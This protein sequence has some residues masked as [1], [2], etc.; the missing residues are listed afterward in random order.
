MALQIDPQLIGN[1]SNFGRQ[2]AQQLRQ[3]LLTPVQM[4]PQDLLA[5]NIVSLF[6]GDP[7][8]AA[9][10]EAAKVK[11]QRTQATQIANEQAGLLGEAGAE[12]LRQRDA[13]LLSNADVINSVAT[14]QKQQAA[15]QAK[16]IKQ[17]GLAN[18]RDAVANSASPS[19]IA[20]I[21]RQLL[22]VGAT[23]A[24]LESARDSGRQ[25]KT[26]SANAI[27]VDLR[28]RMLVAVQSGDKEELARIAAEAREALPTFNFSSEYNNALKLNNE[29]MSAVTE[30]NNTTFNADLY[31]NLKEQLGAP[32]AEAYK[33]KPDNEEYFNKLQKGVTEAA[34][35]KA[36]AAELPLIKDRTTFNDAVGGE[37]QNV[38]AESDLSSKEQKKVEEAVFDAVSGLYSQAKDKATVDQVKTLVREALNDPVILEAMRS[39]DVT[40]S[41][42]GWFTGDDTLTGLIRNRLGVPTQSTTTDAVS[43]AQ[44]KLDELRKQQTTAN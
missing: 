5:R 22:S 4:A 15:A 35:A 29:M 36:E 42:P 30:A 31:A 26:E 8:T 10:I 32:V 43:E 44:R 23:A 12:L 41:K 14:V 21:E 19:E 33:S 34:E 38:I 17:T 28:Q 3:G 40:P 18:L 16:G 39:G 6:G 37:I 9:E 2:P 11:Q 20:T 7:R 1:L 27:E 13:G 24:E 25:L